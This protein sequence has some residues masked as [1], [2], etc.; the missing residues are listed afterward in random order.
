MSNIIIMLY[1]I[2]ITA[3]FSASFLFAFIRYIYNALCIRPKSVLSAEILKYRKP[4]PSAR[5]NGRNILI[6]VLITLVLSRLLIFLIGYIGYLITGKTGQYTNNLSYLLTQW[7]ANHYL[8]IAENGY[9]TEGDARLHIVFYPLYPFLVKALTYLFKDTQLSAF[10]L[11]NA[12]LIVSGYILYRLSEL[13]L[14]PSSAHF[15][16]LLF[17]FC[18]AAV[19]FSIPYTESLFFLLTIT[20]VYF[21]K[22]HRFALALLFGA[23]SAFTR[24]PGVACAVPIFYEMLSFKLKRARNIKDHTKRRKFILKN[25]A[26]S[27]AACLTVLTGFFAYLLINKLVTGDAFRFLDYQKNHWGQSFGTVFG[28]SKYTIRY[29]FESPLKWQVRGIWF[30][31]TLILLS[32]AVML[33]VSW[34]CLSPGDYAYALIY[35]LITVSPT[36]LLSGTRYLSAM[37]PAYLMMGYASKRKPLRAALFL[38]QLIM[39]T[40][41]MWMFMVEESFL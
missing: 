11:S 19:F 33:A 13:A 38:I 16:L 3:L 6:S 29:L 24:L 32:V 40:Y 5:S 23:F 30:P 18:P 17:M 35:F 9:V 39:F 21:A 31:Q 22:K 10:I 26:F 15:S 37:Y 12:C 27:F 2:L 34:K 1:P 28:T 20:S 4:A 14:G 25:A 36:S 41:C 7:D 8:G